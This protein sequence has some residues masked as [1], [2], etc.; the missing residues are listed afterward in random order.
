MFVW[1]ASIGFAVLRELH[2]PK[3]IAAPYTGNIRLVVS[4][5]QQT[6]GKVDD[7]RSRSTARY[8]PVAIKI[9]AYTHV[10]GPHD[11]DHMVQMF[12]CIEDRRFSVLAEESF[13]KCDLGYSSFSG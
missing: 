12:H 4:C 3:E 7:F 13:V 5:S 9:G 6:A 8:S 10:F 2:D 11:I 1:I